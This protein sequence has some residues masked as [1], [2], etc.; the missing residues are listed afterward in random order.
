MQNL[1][2][3]LTEANATNHRLS[4]EVESLKSEMASSALKAGHAQE[5]YLA[6]EKANFELTVQLEAAQKSIASLDSETSRRIEELNATILRLQADLQ[7]QQTEEA[8]LRLEV[9]SLH[10]AKDAAVTRA[11][12]VSAKLVAAEAAAAGA[13]AA[14]EQARALE[15]QLSS[16]NDQ[17]NSLREELAKPPAE[18]AAAGSAVAEEA[19]RQLAAAQAQ[20]KAKTSALT[21]A[22][23]DCDRAAGLARET[24]KLLHATAKEL[25]DLKETSASQ[26]AALA[27]EVTAL[28]AQLA[29]SKAQLGETAAKLVGLEAKH[30]NAATL[31]ATADA[32]RESAVAE[33]K[34]DVAALEDKLQRALDD[35]AA[36]RLARDNASANYWNEQKN[37]GETISALQAESAKIQ[38]LQDEVIVWECITGLGCRHWPQ[39]I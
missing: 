2:A 12:D 20:L 34:R 15:A 19:A 7:R 14:E 25:A 39:V 36:M 5:A 24:E 9:R 32:R 10:E 31:L 6:L 18:P 27:A 3:S 13:A 38:G 22:N 33:A 26:H 16:A 8:G 11:N 29:D 17:I 1:S 4:R 30:A 23:E 37:H 28:T 35:A 21:V